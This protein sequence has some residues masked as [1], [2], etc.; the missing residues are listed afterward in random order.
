MESQRRHYW[1]AAMS[2]QPG[3]TLIEL[4]VS[5]G[6]IIILMAIM[7]LFINATQQRYRSQEMLAQVSQGTRSA[8]EVMT[9]ELNQA[10]YNPPF[11]PNKTLGGTPPT[12]D[13]LVHSVTISGSGLATKGIFYGT[14]L[15]IGNNC[16]GTPPVCKQEEVI[17]NSD[18]S[19]GST[20]MTATSFPAILQYAHSANEPIFARTYPYPQGIIL[21]NRTMGNGQAIAVNKIRFFGDIL[22]TGDLYYGEYA[23][24]C[25]GSTV[26][27]WIDACTT[28]C[29][30]GPFT[31]TRFMTKLA[32]PSNGYFKIPASKAAAYDGATISPL[33]D[34]IQG[35]CSTPAGGPGSPP[36][37][38]QWTVYN[39]PDET[40]GGTTPVHARIDYAA[41]TYVPPVLNVNADGTAGAP[42]MWFKVNTYGSYDASTPPIPHFSTYV[43]DV[44]VMLTVQGRQR[45][46]ESGTF[47]VQRLQAHIVPR[48]TNNALNIANNGGATYLPDIPYDP[49]T[50]H[51]LPLP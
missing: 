51:G 1:R 26:G 33:V 10:G 25:S 36:T 41:V 12:P 13:G 14:R 30:T 35:T 5:V 40:T 2:D 28:G 20:G 42:A 17:V 43:L 31:L 9:Q 18:P 21:D 7:F 49:N 3:F 34:N 39:A 45:D 8:M 23:L 27:T 29:T 11:V 6:I 47:R 44:R 4:L 46:P 16:P 19:Y 24:Q 32:D 50:A 22:D 38:T 48:N 15:V 37:W